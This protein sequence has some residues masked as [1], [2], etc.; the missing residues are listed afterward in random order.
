MLV[1][2][3]WGL[4]HT[5]NHRACRNQMFLPPCFLPRLKTKSHQ[6]H[7]VTILILHIQVSA[8][9]MFPWEWGNVVCVLLTFIAAALK[10]TSVFHL[11]DPEAAK[12]VQSFFFLFFEVSCC[13]L[14]WKAV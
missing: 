9:L 14:L 3:N 5:V 7:P 10:M 13:C 8:W 6:N 11:Q 12:T 2:E 1:S 4:W